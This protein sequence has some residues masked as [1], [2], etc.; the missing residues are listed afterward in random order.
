MVAGGTVTGGNLHTTGQI[1]DGTMIIQTG[2]LTSVGNIAAANVNLSGLADV[3]GNIDGGNINTAGAVVATGNIS[4]GNI[5]TPKW[6][7]CS[8]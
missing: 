2:S 8:C 3:T 6:Q 1:T 7:G 4:G 5:N